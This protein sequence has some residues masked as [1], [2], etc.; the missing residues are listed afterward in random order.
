MNNFNEIDLNVCRA[1]W[2]NACKSPNEDVGVVINRFAPF[3]TALVCARRW[4]NGDKESGKKAITIMSTVF[5]G[6][7]TSEAPYIGLPL[8][9]EEDG[10]IHHYVTNSVVRQL[11]DQMAE[12]ELT[13]KNIIRACVD[14]QAIARM[15]AEGT[16]DAA[17]TAVNVLIE[18]MKNLKKLK[19]ASKLDLNLRM[20]WKSESVKLSLS[21]EGT[22]KRVVV[23]DI[24]HELRL[25]GMKEAAQLARFFIDKK[26]QMP[27]E[28]MAHATLFATKPEN[29][30][31]LALTRKAKMMYWTLC[32]VRRNTEKERC[33]GLKDK[34][35]ISQVKKA[36]KPAYDVQFEALA[37][38]LRVGYANLDV[39]EKVCL[40]LYVTFEDAKS[41]AKTEVSRFAQ[42]LMGEEFFNFVLGIYEGDDSVCQYTEDALIRCNGYEDGDTAEF[43]F[44]EAEED[45]K[46]A[47]AK[48]ASLEGEFLIRKNREGKMVASRKIS[49]VIAAPEGDSSQ[50][51]FV[52][53][54]NIRNTA[55]T[56]KMLEGVL[57]K[58][59]DVQLVPYNKQF[60]LRDAV[61]INGKKV[62]EFACDTGKNDQKAANA[63]LS[64]MYSVKGKVASAV[65]GLVETSN[66]CFYL[67]AIVTLNDCVKTKTVD[68]YLGEDMV[69][70]KIRKATAAESKAKVMTRNTQSYKA[71]S[72]ALPGLSKK[73]AV[74]PQVKA[75]GR[76]AMSKGR[77]VTTG[78]KDSILL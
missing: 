73:T 74:R 28:I 71:C 66:H 23:N 24:F 41:S 76:P 10:N 51:T 47:M 7:H 53:K 20:D 13:P 44:G 69:D 18:N 22:E 21:K 31:L 77:G 6:A 45:G 54:M 63:Y 60:G 14:L 16:I 12:M 62:F 48:D 72:D 42:D 46:F 57:T 36:I 56:R 37:N 55:Q 61:L 17:K 19:A 43:V 25:E 78:K 65:Y 38:M 70:A 9:I 52:T 8:G 1:N 29:A 35:L 3:S 49:D 67:Q 27:S 15:Y 58:D 11:F 32:Q 30:S 4:E 59:M 75:Q 5:P 50:V 33:E 68:N 2:L 26:Q 39:Y 40:L 64:N 34:Q